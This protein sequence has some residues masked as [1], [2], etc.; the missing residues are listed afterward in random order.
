MEE[1]GREGRKVKAEG[2][3]EEREKV[4]PTIGGGH[5][6]DG[7]GRGYAHPRH[8]LVL[9]MVSPQVSS[10]LGWSPTPM[11]A[12]PA[13]LEPWILCPFSAS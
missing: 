7:L 8:H 4:R 2:G 10:C 3:R 12:S 11:E 1:E 5:G 9:L 6:G 13:L